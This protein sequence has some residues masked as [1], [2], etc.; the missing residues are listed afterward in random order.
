MATLLFVFRIRLRR[1]RGVVFRYDRRLVFFFIAVAVVVVVVVMVVMIEK[2]LSIE[3]CWW[4][5]SIRYFRCLLPQM[6]QI[7]VLEK[8]CIPIECRATPSK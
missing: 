2:E 3:V 5:F 8:T 6:N 4:Q 1:Q 7:D